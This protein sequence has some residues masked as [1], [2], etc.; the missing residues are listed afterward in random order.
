MEIQRVIDFVVLAH[1]GQRRNTGCPYIV[2]PMAVLS[3][4]ACWGITNVVT[5]NAALCHDVREDCGLEYAEVRDVIGEEAADVVEELSFFFDPY[6]SLSK[7]QQKKAYMASFGDKS[8]HALVG[9]VADRLCN[10]RDYFEAD[11]EYAAVYWRKA[12]PLLDAM[13]VRRKEIG[14]FFGSESVFS[15][16]ETSA[17]KLNRALS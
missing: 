11:D 15:R 16:M 4:V 2:H 1:T 6:D 3:Q 12:S 9:K 5:W 8:I 13:F 17:F 7:A 10:T 14:D